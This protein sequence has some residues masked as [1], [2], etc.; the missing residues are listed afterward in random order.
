MDPARDAF[1]PFMLGVCGAAGALD[2]GGN[3]TLLG[4]PLP[5]A[6]EGP[7]VAAGSEAPSMLRRRDG[8][9]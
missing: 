6:D 8:R 7:G 3:T 9:L 2:M 4:R 1:K 5:D